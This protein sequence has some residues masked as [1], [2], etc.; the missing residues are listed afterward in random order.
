M[1]QFLESV[2]FKIL[3]ILIFIGNCQAAAIKVLAWDGSSEV[4]VDEITTEQYQRTLTLIKSALDTQ[5]ISGLAN[6][7]EQGPSWRLAKI[8]LGLGASGEIGIGPFK[9]G[10]ALKQ[11][12]IYS[13]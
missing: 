3:V 11:R 8:S 9:F 1:F 4:I 2:M 7:Q 13:R 6:Y 12:F 10:K 5:I